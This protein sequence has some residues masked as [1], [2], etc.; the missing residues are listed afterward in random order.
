MSKAV[1]NVGGA[2]KQLPIPD[3]YAGWRHDLLDIDPAVGP[4]IVLDARRLDTLAPANYDAV[5]CSHNIEH[6]HR[7]DAAKVVR[8]MAHVLKPDGFVELRLPDI[9]NVLRYIVE[10]DLDVD[11]PLY[12]I[13]EGPVL[14]RDALWGYHPQIERSGNDFYAHK[15]GFSRQALISFM[16]ENG[17]PNAVVGNGTQFEIIGYFFLSTPTKEQIA[18][19]D[20][21]VE[22][23]PDGTLRERAV[24]TGSDHVA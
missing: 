9:K 23:H 15:T 21:P 4:D 20:L 3:Y 22:P 6:Y 24:T 14:V 1:L 19:L 8:G 17:F 5:Y 16:I 10:K 12:H 13:P 11:D 7:H 2:S 18:L